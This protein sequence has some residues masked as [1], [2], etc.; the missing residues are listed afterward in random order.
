MTSTGCLLFFRYT[1]PVKIK[2]LLEIYPTP[3]YYNSY[4]TM[5]KGE[6]CIRITKI[7]CAA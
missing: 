1:A 7:N 3:V 4:K 6:Q 2:I 5:P